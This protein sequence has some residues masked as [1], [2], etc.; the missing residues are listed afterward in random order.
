M[1]ITTIWRYPVK[2]MAGEH[3]RSAQLTNAGLL[4]DRVVQSTPLRDDDVRSGHDSA[5]S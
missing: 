3:V 4:G 2:S 5:G 1:T